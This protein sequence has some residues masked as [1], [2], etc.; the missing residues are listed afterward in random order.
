M[1]PH[2]NTGFQHL[3]LAPK[4]LGLIES[5]KFVKPTPIQHKAIP[6][7]LEGNDI[8]GVA[9][10]GTGK[11]MAFGIPMIQRLMST[12]GKGLVLVPTRELALQVEEV[13]HPVAKQFQLKTVVLIGGAS[14]YTQIKELRKNPSII[15]ATPGRLI[16][17][18]EQR[19]VQLK[20]VRILVLDEA[21]RMLDMGFQPQV[22]R[23]L[24]SVPQDRQTMLFSATIPPDIVSLASRHMKLPI[25][26]EIA[27]SGTA[28]A[29]VT[30][31]LFIVAHDKKKDVMEMLLNQYS[32]AVL[33]FTR[34]KNKARSITR[35]LKD[36]GHKAAEIH[37]NRS[38]AQRKQAMNGFKSGQYRIL[39]AT[40]IAS[41]GLDVTGIELV[42]NYDLPEDIENYV[43]RIGRTGRAEK[44]GH[45]VSL[46]TPDQG[47]DVERIEKLIRKPL[48][49][50][51]HPDF[52]GHEFI[53]GARSPSRGGGRGS[54]P[55][56]GG[57]QRS[58]NSRGDSRGYGKG[59]S[60]GKSS[61]GQRQKRS[62]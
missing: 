57:G 13:L 54:K 23:I 9:Q 19:N 7:A 5:M 27:P 59:N 31:E 46:A 11:T 50:M 45:A 61:R 56:R 33:V 47:S 35:M 60:R 48:P 43:H 6:V 10:T 29:S 8:V 28:A 53:K 49:R 58:G 40:D 62:Y 21:D 55:Y 20:D 36:F 1:I 3:G 39:V 15:I 2:E 52:V 30:Q 14:S 16:D 51:K 32:G 37:S 38:M 26:V 4:M 25:H 42:I 41:R 18:L 17:H 22:E 12:Q 44:S 34:T 24:R